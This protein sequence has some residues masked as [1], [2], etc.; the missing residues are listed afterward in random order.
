MQEAG[1]SVGFAWIIFFGGL[2]VFAFVAFPTI[3]TGVRQRRVALVLSRIEQA[4][5]L[6]LPLVGMLRTSSFEGRITVSRLTRI[7]QQLSL[8]NSL[9]SSLEHALPELPPRERSLIAV[10]EESGSL[11]N[12][13][14]RLVQEEQERRPADSVAAV[15]TYIVV[16]AASIATVV[17]TLSIFVIPKYQAIYKDMTKHAYENFDLLRDGVV[18][19]MTL[20][21]LSLIVL[22]IWFIRTVFFVHR[23]RWGWIDWL[24]WHMPLAHGLARD[25]GLADVFRTLANGLSAGRTLHSAM[26]DACRL[27]INAVQHRRIVRF[28]QAVDS[29]ESLANAGRRGR[30]PGLAVGFLATA[31]ASQTLVETTGFLAS[32]YEGRFSRLRILVSAAAVPAMTLVFGALV[33]AVALLL[34][35]PMLLILSSLDHNYGTFP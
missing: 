18:L 28:A 22:I 4:V 33:C 15:R 9:A 2:F 35:R 11:G 27:R 21:Q 17:S 31:Q 26:G 3:L 5:R 10:A 29:G 14:S 1:L 34:F 7:A 25:R 12:A 30:F 13:L 8:G 32:Y 16:I 24:V 23:R 19:L 6:N 20:V